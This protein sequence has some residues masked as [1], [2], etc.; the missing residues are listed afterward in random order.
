METYLETRRIK[1]SVWIFQSLGERHGA[2]HMQPVATPYQTK[3]WLQ[4]RR[5]KAHVMGTTYVYDFPELFKSALR[6]QWERAIKMG[7]ASKMPDELMEFNE[8][9]LDE[10]GK[11]L[12]FSR[13]PGTPS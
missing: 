8:L 13:P 4:P 6:N 1:D 3:E 12:E 7:I 5:Y 9:V 11:L 2:L 10:N